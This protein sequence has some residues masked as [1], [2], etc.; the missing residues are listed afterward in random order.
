[1]FRA[2]GRLADSDYLARFGFIPSPQTAKGQAFDGKAPLF[3]YRDDGPPNVYNAAERDRIVKYPDNRDGLPVGFARLDSGT[4]PTARTGYPDQIGFTCA[5]CHTGHLEYKNVSIRFDGGPA[6]VDLG[7]LEPAIA[8]SIVYTLKVPG[9]FDRFAERLAK[10]NADWPNWT[11]KSKLRKEL[12]ETFNKIVVTSTWA[13]QSSNLPPVEEGYGRLDALNRIGNQVFFENLLPDDIGA[14]DLNKLPRVP[15]HVANNFAPID[16]PVS[17]PPIWD[18]PTFLWA[19]YDAS[20]LNELVRNAGESLGVGAKINMTGADT[21]RHFSSSIQIAT[22]VEMEK[23]LRGTDPLAGERHAFDGLTAPK[24]SDAASIFKGDQDWEVDAEKVKRGRQLYR[25][26]CVE[27]HRGPVRDAEFDKLWP[28]LSFWSAKSPD[29]DEAN[30]MKIGDRNYFNVV[31]KRV[32]DM[33]TDEQQSRV[34]AERKVALPAALNVKPVATLN[35][36]SNCGLPDLEGVNT[37]FGV[38]LMAVVDRTID[39]WFADNPIPSDDEKA[40]RG[41][42]PNC[43]NP[44]TF[45]VMGKNGD[46]VT[47][48]E[49]VVPY[50]RARP[51]DGVWATA[52]YLHNGSVPTL[53]AMLVPQGER[54]KR[55]CVG[56][57]QFDPKNVGLGTGPLPCATGLTT[58]DVNELGNSNL[59]HSFEGTETDVRKLP[60]GIIGRALTNGERDDLIEY[61]KT[62]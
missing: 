5:A 6:M 27:C 28:E 58:I 59:G 40:M 3:G 43:P 30:W 9:R 33:G 19:Q 36:R 62:L 47:G 26:F 20:I 60:P 8:L 41:P 15:R 39:R 12:E 35:D 18:T 44:R 51:L 32:V 55:F 54:P 37:A 29:R 45:T 53:R 22:I 13:R 10:R 16:A 52:P 49:K 23:M 31:Q 25:T 24:W 38:A 4:D 61:L 2:P 46:Q 14:M 17:F 21:S 11:D 7:K 42:R 1:M 50:Y 34:L 48:A 57:R 56:S